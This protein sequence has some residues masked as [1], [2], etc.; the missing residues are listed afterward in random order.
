MMPCSPNVRF[1]FI[2]D[3]TLN[4]GLI[5]RSIF[6]QPSKTVGRHVLGASEFLSCSE[7]AAKFTSTLRKKGKDVECVFVECTLKEYE[8]IWG[9]IGTEIGLMMQYI[10]EFGEESFNVVTGDKVML[11]A[12]DLGIE[13][14]RNTE[15]R[16][17]AEN[18][19]YI[20]N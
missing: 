6:A 16:L 10:K 3:E 13:G 9:P 4:I 8:G 18:W 7:W 2:G 5:A 12:E 20:A 1:P 11:T 19:E 17:D 15:E 14:M